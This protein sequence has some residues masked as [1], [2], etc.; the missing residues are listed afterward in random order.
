MDGPAKPAP[1]RS[2]SPSAASGTY[3]PL[4]TPC[5]S[6][7]CTSRVCT[8]WAARPA[9][10]WATRSVSRTSVKADPGGLEFGVLVEGVQRLVA[11]IAA[12]LVAPERHGDVVLVVLV[13]VPR[14]GAQAARYA[15]GAVEVVA[16]DA[17]LQ[18]VARG[19]G[20]AQ[21]LGLVGKADHA[22]HRAEDLLA[23][24]LHVVADAVE[25]GRL[26]I[27]AAGL[28]AH[29]TA[30]GH[31]AAALGVAGLDVA[32]HR[33]QLAFVDQ[34]AQLGGRVQ[35]IA[36]DVL[37]RLGGDQAHELVGHAV[38]HQH[39]RGRVAALALVEEHAA[40]HGAG[41][42]RQVLVVVEHQ[43]GRLA[44]ELVVD[45]LEVGLA[46][47]VQHAAAHSGGAGEAD[48]VDV[49]VQRQRLAGLVAVARDHVEDA[50]RDAGLDG[51]LGQAQ[52]RVR[53]R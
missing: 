10:R 50:R 25:D 51:Q 22:H 7:N 1:L 3:L 19:I 38:L 30:T 37:G 32:Q 13:D 16:P 46:G 5:R 9:C 34:G 35:G 40:G 29:L 53:A 24:D 41:G 31:A 44:A 4:A 47:V 42:A 2:T 28:L 43:E 18:A 11:A 17:G 52:G 33:A 12:L 20:Q 23:G 15:V 14:A 6:V 49:H 8:P 39:A 48:R 21:G 45:A 26:D 27:E 36:G